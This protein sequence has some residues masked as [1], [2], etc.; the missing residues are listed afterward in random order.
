M[1]G[2]ASPRPVG[3]LRPSVDQPGR[4]V[5]QPKPLIGGPEQYCTNPYIKYVKAIRIFGL[6]EVLNQLMTSQWYHK[7]IS[8]S[9]TVRVLWLY[10]PEPDDLSYAS[11]P[12][13]GSDKRRL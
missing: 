13:D 8:S 7:K 11:P 2:E 3:Q 12:K 1:T 10:S 9:G 4:P 5:G 6:L